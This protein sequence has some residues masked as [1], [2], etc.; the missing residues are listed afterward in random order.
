[1]LLRGSHGVVLDGVFTV[2]NGQA[3]LVEAGAGLA[4]LEDAHAGGRG[5][6]VQIRLPPVCQCQGGGTKCESSEDAT[7]T[8]WDEEATV[9]AGS[10]RRQMPPR[11][12]SQICEERRGKERTKT[13][14]KTRKKKKPMPRPG[15]FA[16]A[17]PFTH[18]PNLNPVVSPTPRTTSTH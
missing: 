10:M 2:R 15:E 13:R 17:R 3:L 16:S 12:T 7:A 14:E 8:F 5:Y 4:A 18:H 1:M 11:M 6:W 9:K